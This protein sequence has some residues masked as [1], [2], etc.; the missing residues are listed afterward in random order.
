M[1]GL[2]R[3]NDALSYV[4]AHLVEEEEPDIGEAARLACCGEHHFRRMF[5]SLA[6]VS[7]T[8]YVRRRRLTLAAFELIGSEARIIDIAVKYGYG[9]PDAFAR[10]F[11]GL[12]GLTPSEA[13]RLGQ[14][15]KA[16][17]RMTFRLTIEGG[18]EMNYRLVEKEAFRIVGIMKRVP[19]IYEGVN[20]H[21]AEMWSSL[22]AERIAELKALSDIEP[23]GLISASVNFAEG[24]EEHGQLD[25]Y[26]GAA[27]TQACPPHLAALEVAASEWAVFEAV[28]AFP[29]A[30]QSVWGRIY[31]EWFPS[32]SYELAPGPELLWNEGKDTSK[33]DYRSEIWIP[34]RRQ[35]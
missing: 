16:Y 20:P 23:G 22:T 11:Q 21:I 33:P 25:Q 6:G 31:A 28:G 3:L 27:T 19:L 29:S 15:L 13:R 1:N 24:R 34:V 5:A 32:S 18:D 8:E 4:E 10:A 30:L 17:P 14:P 35:R 9:S 7:L 26:I 12:H 2:E